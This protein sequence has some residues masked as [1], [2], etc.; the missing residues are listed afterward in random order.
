MKYRNKPKY[1]GR[2]ISTHWNRR[3][4]EKNNSKLRKHLHKFDNT[5]ATNIQHN[6]IQKHAENGKRLQ[7]PF[8]NFFDFQ[9]SCLCTHR[10]SSYS[11]NHNVFK[12]QALERWD[13]IYTSPLAKSLLIACLIIH[14]TV[15]Y[16]H[17]T[18]QSQFKYHVLSCYWTGSKITFQG[19]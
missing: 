8:N 13:P 9:L 16:V 2:E 5:H 6:Q 3:K 7:R 10:I 1:D 18:Q 4:Q 15:L 11:L 12:M 14:Q 19:S 17:S